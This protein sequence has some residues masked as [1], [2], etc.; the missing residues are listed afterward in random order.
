MENF[1]YYEILEIEKSSNRDEIKRSYREL[2]MKYHPDRNSGDKDAEEM[3]KRINEAYQVLSDDEKRAIYDRHGK[4]GLKS[5]GFS[6]F[7]ERDFGDIFGDIGD[8]FESVFGQGF[9]GFSSG[10]KTVAHAEYSG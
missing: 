10:H 3:F 9:S 7:S 6:G 5:Q 1:D 8:I 4:D 2:A